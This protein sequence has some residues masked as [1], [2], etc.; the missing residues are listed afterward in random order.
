MVIHIRLYRCDSCK[1]YKSNKKSMQHTTT[2]NDFYTNIFTRGFFW[3]E[4]TLSGFIY[5]ISVVDSSVA[6]RN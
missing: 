3:D 5:V 2:C 4:V 1:E 6:A